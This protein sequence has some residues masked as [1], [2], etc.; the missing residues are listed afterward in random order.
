MQGRSCGRCSGGKG[1]AGNSRR[2]GKGRRAFDLLSTSMTVVSELVLLWKLNCS[3]GLM[4]ANSIGGEPAFR[5]MV[6]HTYRATKRAVYAASQQADAIACPMGSGETT[7][8]SI[9]ILSTIAMTT[10]G[11]ASMLSRRNSVRSP[12]RSIPCTLSDAFQA[13]ADIDTSRLPRGISRI[14]CVPQ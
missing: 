2:L 14:Y 12:K 4:H 3:R 8:R 5:A 6:C 9:E 7:P 10:I 1:S 13:K 11:T